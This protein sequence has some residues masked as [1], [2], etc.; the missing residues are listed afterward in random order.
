MMPYRIVMYIMCLI[1]RMLGTFGLDT[2]NKHTKKRIYTV[3]VDF[4]FQAK[5]HEKGTSKMNLL[6]KSTKS[7]SFSVYIYIHQKFQTS[8]EVSKTEI[9]AVG[10]SWC[11]TNV[12]EVLLKG[13][14]MTLKNK[15]SLRHNI[16]SEVI[17]LLVGK[18]RFFAYVYFTK[19]KMSY[20][21]Y[22]PTNQV[23]FCFIS[24]VINKIITF[25]F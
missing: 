12:G 4:W 18:V 25:N 2:L 22:Y 20:P 5:K 10:E 7:Y 21:H 15:T 19:F 24:V 9:L 17:H 13:Q 11:F 6:R 1:I 14:I 16:F 23:K 8:S 3:N